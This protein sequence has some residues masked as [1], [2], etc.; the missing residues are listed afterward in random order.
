MD[1]V[2]MD[3]MNNTAHFWNKVSLLYQ[4]KFMDLDIYNSS[5]DQFV[6]LVAKPKARI[7]DIGCGPG[8]ITKYLLK[9]RPDFYVEGIDIAPNMV[10]L[11]KVNNP[12]AGFTVLDSRQIKEL[13]TRFD[14]IIC[15]FC[16]PYL[17]QE[18]RLLFIEDIFHLLAQEGV[19]YLSFVEGDPRNSGYK[20][21]SSGDSIYFN[22]HTLDS[23]L[24]QLEDIGFMHTLI[25]KVVYKRSME[26]S[27]RHTIVIARK[28]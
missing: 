23:I 14:G 6:D 13:N 25:E 24:K 1:G 5:Y 11:A 27:E 10:A 19:F 15:G 9:K 16:L 28:P 12:E 18:E 2:N 22:Y 3:D 21:G 20:V 7:L 4:E 26:E 8:N 17:S